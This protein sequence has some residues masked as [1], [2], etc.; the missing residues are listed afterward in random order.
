MRKATEIQELMTEIA[1]NPA[2]YDVSNEISDLRLLRSVGVGSPKGAGFSVFEGSFSNVDNLTDKGFNTVIVHL[3]GA[4]VHWGERDSGA[5]GTAGQGT[6]TIDPTQIER[7]GESTGN[8]RFAHCYLGE[9]FLQDLGREIAPGAEFDVGLENVV[10]QFDEPLTQMVKMIANRLLLNE[11]IEDL[12]LTA[13]GQLVGLHLLRNYSRIS[14]RAL[15]RKPRGLSRN[16]LND[17][18]DFIDNALDTKLSLKKLATLA[19]LTP[20]H[21]ARSFRDA[22]GQSPHAFVIGR[23][24]D[25]AKSQLESDSADLADVALNT[26]FSSQQHFTAAFRKVT[27]MTPGKYRERVAPKIVVQN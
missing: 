6:V 21:F 3:S 14:G 25:L 13:I 11:T 26:G 27:G 17:V 4:K 23:R 19:E 10:G 22:V 1:L 9:T 20:Y 18:I 15:V 8:L 12:E 16:K 2:I 7:R 5:I 24:I